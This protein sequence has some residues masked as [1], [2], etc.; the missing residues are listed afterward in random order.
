MVLQVRMIWLDSKFD[1]EKDKVSINDIW[2]LY[3]ITRESF[4]I[5]WYPAKRALPAM[6]THGR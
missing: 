6:F 1:S 3:D 5:R 4:I 2:L